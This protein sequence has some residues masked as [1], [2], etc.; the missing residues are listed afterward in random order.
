[1]KEGMIDINEALDTLWHAT[2]SGQ[3]PHP[4]LEKALPFEDAYRIQ[5]AIL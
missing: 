5:L 1:M 3:Y 2:Q 4:G